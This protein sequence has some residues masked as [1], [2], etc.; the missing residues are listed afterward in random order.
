MTIIQLF[1]I[2]NGFLFFGMLIYMWLPEPLRLLLGALLQK[3]PRKGL[4]WVIHTLL[5][6]RGTSLL[7]YLHVLLVDQ[8]LVSVLAE[9]VIL[10]FV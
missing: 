6:S 8:M 7:N 2:L 1:F 9:E 5:V 4:R 3:L 10:P